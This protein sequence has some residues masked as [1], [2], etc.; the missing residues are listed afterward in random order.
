MAA[1][2]RSKRQ[3]RKMPLGECALC[4][5][6]PQPSPSRDIIG[7]TAPDAYREARARPRPK[8][9]CWLAVATMSTEEEA[10]QRGTPANLN[11]GQPRLAPRRHGPIPR[12]A[13]RHHLAVTQAGITLMSHLPWG[14]VLMPRQT[15]GFPRVVNTPVHGFCWQRWG[16]RNAPTGSPMK[17]G[18]HRALFASVPVT[19]TRWWQV[20]WSSRHR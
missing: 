9:R 14:G 20:V 4:K 15:R 3:N 10:A 16:N 2:A 19:P 12:P 17:K 18:P 11:A 8:A 6:R 5:W 1:T 7:L 13:A